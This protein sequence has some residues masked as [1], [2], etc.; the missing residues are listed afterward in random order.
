[1]EYNALCLSKDELEMFNRATS[2]RTNS[3][4]SSEIRKDEGMHQET[5]LPKQGGHDKGVN[6]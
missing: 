6:R 5:A 4:R 1:M 3:P 2:A